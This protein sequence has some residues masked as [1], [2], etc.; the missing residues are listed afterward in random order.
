MK[1]IVF[2]FFITLV[3]GCASTK[4]DYVFDG[5]TVESTKQGVSDVTKRLKPSEQLA[6][7]KAL[8]AIQFSDVRS[9]YDI[10]DDPTMT[11]EM[12]YFII[13]KKIDGLNYYEVLELAKSSPTKVSVSSK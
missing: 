4:S 6:F 12:N 7:L 8:M 10:L 9:V 3:A 11:D 13:G 1:H 5:S 2:A